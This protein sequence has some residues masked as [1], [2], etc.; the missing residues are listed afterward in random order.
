MR[1]LLGG[2][3]LGPLG[4]PFMP[5][6]GMQDTV[7]SS[8][9]PKAKRTSSFANP[10]ASNLDRTRCRFPFSSYLIERNAYRQATN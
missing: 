5:I 8:S 9:K 6:Q 2:W 10:M 4:R 1:E 3:L 7:V